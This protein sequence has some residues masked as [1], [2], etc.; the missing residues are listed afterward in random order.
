[1]F[2][3]RIAIRA[4]VIYG[5]PCAD[6]DYYDDLDADGLYD[7]WEELHQ[8]NISVDDSAD[9]ADGDGWTNQKEFDAGTDPQNTDTD[10]DGTKDKKD[11]DP[12]DP[13]R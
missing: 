2:T 8:L 6:F 3:V 10:G 1:M 9:D 11:A 5:G 4:R 13:N 12:L 7:G